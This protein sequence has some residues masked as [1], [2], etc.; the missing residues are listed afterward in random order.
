MNN[1]ENESCGNSYMWKEIKKWRNDLCGKINYVE[2]V[3]CGNK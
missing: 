3:T 1:L 2:I